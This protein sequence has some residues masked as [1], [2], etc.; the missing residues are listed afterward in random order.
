[1]GMVWIACG[2]GS[3]SRTVAVCDRRRNCSWVVHGLGA[4]TMAAAGRAWRRGD[5]I[6]RGS[7]EI[8]ARLD[9]FFLLSRR[10]RVLFI[11]SL[12]RSH[13]VVYLQVGFCGGVAG[14]GAAK[15]VVRDG[16]EIHGLGD[17]LMWW[18]EFVNEALDG[19]E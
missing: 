4:A 10:P 11:S 6:G 13:P 3:G 14:K 12:L 5:E 15:V 17:L 18:L 16:E 1:M 19:C 8:W 9:P 7:T 2:F